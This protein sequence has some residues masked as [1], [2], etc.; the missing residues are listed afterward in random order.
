MKNQHYF[1]NGFLWFVTKLTLGDS[2]NLHKHNFFVDDYN[3]I[4]KEVFEM[5]DEKFLKKFTGYY[6]KK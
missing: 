4:C 2:I 1:N 3:K 5:P 6:V